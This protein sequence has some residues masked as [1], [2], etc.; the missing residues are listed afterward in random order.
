[1]K[2]RDTVK[3]AYQI[4]LQKSDLEG[5]SLLKEPDGSLNVYAE[6]FLAEFEEE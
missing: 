6:Y 5:L 2:I 3:T 1:M 4:K